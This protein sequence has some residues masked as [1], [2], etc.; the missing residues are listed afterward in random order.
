MKAHNIS[1]M[2]Q[3]TK[4]KYRNLW[5]KKWFNNLASFALA[6]SLAK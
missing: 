5:G 6:D 1:Q 2:K 3:L 4:E